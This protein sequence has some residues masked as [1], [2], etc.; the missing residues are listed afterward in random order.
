MEER[1]RTRG[2]EEGKKIEKETLRMHGDDGRIGEGRRGPA[3]RGFRR[4]GF[5]DKFS[6]IGSFGADSPSAP[7]PTCVQIEGF[8]ESCDIPPRRKRGK[9]RGNA[10]NEKQ[11]DGGERERKIPKRRKGESRNG[12]VKGGGGRKEWDGNANVSL[13]ESRRDCCVETSANS[14]CLPRL[15]PNQAVSS[16]NVDEPTC[17]LTS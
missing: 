14:R 12:R 16:L 5:L 6:A 15:A 4:G 10:R 3:A 13:R 1:D 7:P 8:R 11:A 17:L 9:D 2:C